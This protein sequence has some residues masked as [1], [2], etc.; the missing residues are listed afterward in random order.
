MIKER[1]S[2]IQSRR[3]LI[4]LLILTPLGFYTKY[5][6]GPLQDWVRNS[7]GGV[8][9]EI[10]WC[11]VLGLLFRRLRPVAIAGVVFLVT[12]G[13][14]FAQLWHPPFLEY[15]RSTFMGMTILGNS[16][17]WSDF[18]YYFVGSALGFVLLMRLIP[19]SDKTD[20]ADCPR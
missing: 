7:L 13:L 16:F 19:G 8:F 20:Q 12:C 11:L 17:T 15:L 2:G 6:T 14:E 4:A 9:Y 10:F 1:L 3:I 5:Y 18:P